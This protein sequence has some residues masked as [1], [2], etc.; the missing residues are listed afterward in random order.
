MAPT[1]ARLGPGHH[2]KEEEK[3]KKS[4]KLFSGQ[5]TVQWG[6][7][8]SRSTHAARRS[9]ASGRSRRRRKSTTVRCHGANC[10]NRTGDIPC[11]SIFDRFIGYG[12]SRGPT[13]GV[14]EISQS[15]FFTVRALDRPSSTSRVVRSQ[16]NM[17][18]KPRSLKNEPAP[19][20]RLRSRPRTFLPSFPSRC[21]SPGRAAT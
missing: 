15:P 3:A 9:R 1:S 17:P 21:V 10:E 12:C 6:C 7:T 14:T 20:A 19:H 13:A 5:L 11:R 18:A 16:K 8:C 4:G 2:E